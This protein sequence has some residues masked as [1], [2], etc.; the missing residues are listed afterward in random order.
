MQPLSM[1]AA[2]LSSVSL[3]DFALNQLD[4]GDLADIWITK[5]YSSYEL[6]VNRDNISICST[7]DMIAISKN[8]ELVK[9]L[10]SVEFSRH[11]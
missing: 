10:D 2:M 8:D 9:K 6:Y 11:Q 1:M 7:I 4:E 3:Y 5:D